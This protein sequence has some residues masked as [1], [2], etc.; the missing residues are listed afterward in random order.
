MNFAIILSGGVGSR[1][2]AKM[3]KQY[4]TVKDKPILIYTLE[5]FSQISDIDCIIVVAA[6]QWQ[7]KIEEWINKY[8]IDT[9]FRF[10][11][12]GGTR[13]ESILN[14]LKECNSCS[15]SDN[16][17]IHD[18]VRPLVSRKIIEQC[19]DVLDNA[20]A[21]MPVIAVQD[22]IYVSGDRKIVTGLLNRDTLFAGQAPE[23]Y[24]LTK[25]LEINNNLNKEELGKIRGS[26]E[27]AFK[28]G[29][30]VQLIDGDIGNFKITTPQDLE[31]FK[32]IL[33]GVK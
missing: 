1:F 6:E 22:T 18:A 7:P 30:K 31:R 16:V 10:A 14:G 29:L 20:D 2:G 9:T 3:P 32:Q 27:L 4:L 13:Q 11:K 33:D 21:V 17:I 26:S 24:K 23:G 19:L 8:K 5:K 15:E 25:Y 28:G 12:S